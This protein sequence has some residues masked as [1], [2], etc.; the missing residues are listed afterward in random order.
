MIT[1]IDA[2]RD[3][4]GSF[5][6][7]GDWRVKHRE[8][9]EAL[10]REFRVPFRDNGNSFASCFK[11]LGKA[12][13]GKLTGRVKIYWKNLALFQ[14]F[15]VSQSLGMNTKALYYPSTRMGQVLRESRGEGLSRIEITFTADD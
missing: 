6:A 1:K 15:S 7:P 3:L 4:R 5:Y 13:L 12:E 8:L 11:F 2:T 14:S 10:Q 9:A